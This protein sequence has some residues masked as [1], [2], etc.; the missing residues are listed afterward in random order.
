MNEELIHI[1]KVSNLQLGEEY[2]INWIEES[3]A[4]I[5]RV[6]GGFELEDCSYGNVSS[7]YFYTENDVEALVKEAMTFI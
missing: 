7:N 1:S 4:L 5:T 6:E 3:G 2:T